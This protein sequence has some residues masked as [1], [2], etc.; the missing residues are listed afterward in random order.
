MAEAGKALDEH[1]KALDEDAFKRLDEALDESQKALTERRTSLESSLTVAEAGLRGREEELEQAVA[2]LDKALEHAEDAF[3]Q[4]ET[5]LATA[6]GKVVDGL[7]KREGEWEEACRALRE[8]LDRVYD[9]MDGRAEEERASAVE[10]LRALV[11][12]EVEVNLE[13][14]FPEL[15]EA[16]QAAVGEADLPAALQ[17]IDRVRRWIGRNDEHAASKLAALAPDLATA[18]AVADE[19][20]ELLRSVAE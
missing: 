18:K 12:D 4:Q 16:P 9:A 14:L 15:V 13:A 10:R 6:V 8:D 19:V 7:E 5:A 1:V 17:R 2:D 3:G 20:A 11:E